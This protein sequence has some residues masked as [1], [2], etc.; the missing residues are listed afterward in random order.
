MAAG[1]RAC[2]ARSVLDGREH[3]GILIADGRRC[4]RYRHLKTSENLAQKRRHIRHV[5]PPDAIN[6]AKHAPFKR[7]FSPPL[8]GPAAIDEQASVAFQ[9][10]L[11]SVT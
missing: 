8:T 7:A 5:N 3:D 10:P 1:H 9:T 11:Q 6:P 4:P 2:A